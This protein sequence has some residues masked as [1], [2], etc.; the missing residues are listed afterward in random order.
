MSDHLDDLV[1][2][3]AT[4]QAAAVRDGRV[5]ATA[6]LDA[7]LDR[8]DRYDDRLRAFVTVDVDGARAAARAAD[9][10]VRARTGDLPPFLGVT[11]SVKD[12]IDV[13]G[14]P[15]TH[16]SKVLVDHVATGD[17]PM[18]GRFRDAGFVIL[19]KTNVPEFC[20]SM[21]DSELNG[22]CRNP[23]DTDRTPGGSSG[24]A[25]AALS[26]ALCAASHGTDGA[27]SVRSPASFCGLVGT[28][29]TRGVVDF[30]PEL[31]NPYYGTSGHGVLTRSVR[32]AAALTGVFTEGPAVTLDAPPSLRIAVTTEPPYGTVTEECAAPAL[33]AAEILRGLGHTVATAAPAW[34]VMLA[35]ATFPME[36]PGAAALVPADRIGD[37]EPRNRPL[38][39]RLRSLTVLEHN[40]GVRDVRAGGR[41]VPGVLGRPRRPRLPHRRHRPAARSSG[42]RGTRTRSRT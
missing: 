1:W 7:Y 5:T 26:A 40:E 23:W 33:H 12:V 37:V 13:R 41:H 38:V 17:D 32:D 35:V 3:D 19:G 8:I 29:F 25:A 28:K 24:G 36:V 34:D 4:D 39:E 2:R 15:T 31:G 10:A 18:V 22:T 16:S 30:G 21:T 27:G 9:D 20:S 11:L 42:H 6:L 14:L